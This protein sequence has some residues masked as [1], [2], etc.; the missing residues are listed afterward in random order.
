MEYQKRVGWGVHGR[1][2]CERVESGRMRHGRGEWKGGYERVESERMK[3]GEWK[4]GV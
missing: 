2:E 4:G 3:G 1:V